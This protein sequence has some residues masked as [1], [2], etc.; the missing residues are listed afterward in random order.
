MA[1]KHVSTQV[2]L[3]REH[4]STQGTLALEYVS[5]QSTLARE[6]VFSKQGTQFSRL[7]KLAKICSQSH[8]YLVFLTLMKK[9]HHKSIKLSL[10][11]IIISSLPSLSMPLL[12]ATVGLNVDNMVFFRKN[13]SK[14]FIR[15]LAN[16]FEVAS[17]SKKKSH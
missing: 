3:A 17:F 9:N 10:I 7:E 16:A 8:L 5:T 11:N 13:C 2:T 15:Y 1:R 12:L 6:H 14:I 4:V